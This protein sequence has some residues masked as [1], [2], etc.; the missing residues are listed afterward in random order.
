MVWGKPVNRSALPVSVISKPAGDSE[1]DPEEATFVPTYRMS[2]SDAISKALAKVH[3]SE[4]PN[5]GSGSSAGAKKKGRKNKG[6]V[7]FAT[8]MD[9]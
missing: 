5:A 7:L 8:G 2:M 6:K 9:I 1:T 3:V 4:G